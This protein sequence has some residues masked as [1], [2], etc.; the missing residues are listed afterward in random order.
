VR[1]EHIYKGAGLL[2]L[3]ALCY[4]FFDTLSRVALIIYA[5]AILAV[6]MNAA[7]RAIPLRRPIAVAGM[8]LL[9]LVLLGAGLWFGGG[10]LLR[11][12]RDLA[13]AYPSMERELESW[14]DSARERIGVDVEFVGERVGQAVRAFFGDLSG[15]DVIGGAGG[16]LQALT[17]PVLVF[18]GALFALAK[19]NERLMVPLLRAV[20][21]TRRDDFRR[22]LQLLGERLTGWIKGQIVSMTTIGVLATVAFAIIG[23]PYAFL[24][25]FINGVAEFVPIIGPWVGGIPAVIVAFLQDPMKGLWAAVAILAIQQLESQLITPLVMSKVADVHPFV[26]L[27]AIVL[28]GGLFGFLGILLALPLVLLIW[29]VVEVLWVDRAIHAE[30]DAIEPVVED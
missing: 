11:Q 16:F 5:A 29:T 26:T 8:G 28:F 30:H 12:A 9:A 15:R 17:V 27:F 22:L 20:P 14:G 3:L 21:A 13:D 2:F 18:F 6:A 25:G 4:H 23:V 10:A 7:V 24:L 1:P 19:P